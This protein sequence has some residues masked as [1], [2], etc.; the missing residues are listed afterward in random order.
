MIKIYTSRSNLACRKAKKWL[1]EHELEFEEKNWQHHGMS[2]GEFYKILSLTDNGLLDLI[3][4]RSNAYPEFFKRMSH[5][6]L[7]EIYDTLLREK[8]LLRMPLILDE[9]R[10]QIGFNP[11][12]IRQFI[13]RERRKVML[14]KEKK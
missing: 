11:E 14:K 5:Y 10:L 7:S 4:R 9:Q 1:I 2:L 12:D 8:T 13:P 3:S 6:S